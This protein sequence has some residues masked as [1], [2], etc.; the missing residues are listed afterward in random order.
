LIE[1][2]IFDNHD[3]NVAIKAGRDKEGRQ[4]A[5][6][7]GTELEKIESEYINDGRIGGPSENIIVRDC[8]FKGHYGF[9]IGSE[10]SGSVRNIYCLDNI[11]PQNASGVFLKSS[12]MRGG[13]IEDIYVRGMELS[14]A[15]FVV[16][17]IP[18][19]DA[20]TSSQYLPLFRN[21]YIKDI[22]AENTENGIEIHGWYDQP[23]Q[24]VMLKNIRIENVENKPF[25]IK[26]VQDVELEN[27]TIEGK[28]FDGIYNKRD[29]KSK[30]KQK[31]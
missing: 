8:V 21:V 23:I 14:D 31:I 28:S 26:Q 10:M 2:I 30:P 9:C 22:R 18:N 27:V 3:D 12:R 15:R 5:I 4:G 7:K 1:N 11:A 20:D 6:V 17:L 29:K 25:L 13:T 16:S 24:E 19:Y